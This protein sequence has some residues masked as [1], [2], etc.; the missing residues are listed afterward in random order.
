[1]TSA[2]DGIMNGEDV[3]ISTNSNGKRKAGSGD[4]N[5]EERKEQKMMTRSNIDGSC[6]LIIRIVTLQFLLE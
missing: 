6:S 3:N 1:M 5:P 2:N 4:K